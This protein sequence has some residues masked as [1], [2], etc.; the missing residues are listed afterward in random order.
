MSKLIPVAA[1]FV[2]AI[3]V[4]PVL[5]CQSELLNHNF[6]K[7]AADDVDNLSSG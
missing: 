4:E 7:L 1:L 3:F 2:M 6:R 5:A